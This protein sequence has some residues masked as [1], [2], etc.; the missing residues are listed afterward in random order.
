M[1]DAVDLVS[2][3]ASLAERV[4]HMQDSKL[5]VGPKLFPLIRSYTQQLG[6]VEN[7]S[8]FVLCLGNVIS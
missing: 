5:C 7:Y 1:A 6:S 2:E 8:K 3:D 4:R